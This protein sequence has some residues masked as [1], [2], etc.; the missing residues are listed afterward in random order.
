MDLRIEYV[1]TDYTR[2]KTGLIGTWYDNGFFT[3]GMRQYGFPLGHNMG[4]DAIDIF[5]RST[6]YLTDNLQLGN[7]LN[8]QERQRGQADFERKHET[9]VDLTWWPAPRTQIAPGYTFQRIKNPGEISAVVPF[10]E[11]FDSGVS[12]T[13]HLMWMSFTRNF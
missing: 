7:N 12:V 2:R 4:T 1:D 3:N 8:L 11:T 9:S 5:V 6:R 13:N 10:T